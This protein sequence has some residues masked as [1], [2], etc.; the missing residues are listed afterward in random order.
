MLSGKMALQS[1]MKGNEGFLPSMCIVL[2]IN[3][4]V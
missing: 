4:L 1:W 3:D 2:D